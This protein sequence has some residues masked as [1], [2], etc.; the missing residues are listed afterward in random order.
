MEMSYTSSVVWIFLSI[1][2]LLSTVICV[3]L[4]RDNRNKQML[5]KRFEGN[6]NEFI[7]VLSQKMEFLYGLP[8]FMSD[9]LEPHEGI[10]RRD[11]QASRDAFHLFVAFRLQGWR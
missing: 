10:F 11:R 5:Y 3:M 4:L 8:M 7:V 9:P 1:V 6:L 2:L